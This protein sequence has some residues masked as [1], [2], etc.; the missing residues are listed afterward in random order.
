MRVVFLFALT[1]RVFFVPARE[2]LFYKSLPKFECAILIPAPS[3]GEP[4]RDDLR[5]EA[6]THSLI[7]NGLK[8]R[9]LVGRSAV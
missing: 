6:F 4:T 1:C 5:T 2:T 3:E 8:A 9:H 7:T